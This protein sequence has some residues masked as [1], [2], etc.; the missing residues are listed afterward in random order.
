MSRLLANLTF[1]ALLIWAAPSVAQP[2]NP[3]TT[4]PC[5]GVTSV[6]VTGS[7]LNIA[8]GA[9]VTVRGCNFGNIPGAVYL[10]NA[11]T[12]AGST[13][14]VQQSPSQWQPT[15]V[16]IGSVVVGT[17]ANTGY[18]YVSNT[19]GFINASAPFAVILP[20]P[21]VAPVVTI[22]VPTSAPTFNNGTTA[23]VSLAGTATDTTGVTGCTWTNSL[24]G[25]GNATGT[26]SWSIATIPLMVGT[27]VI[28]VQCLDPALHAG[29][30][31]ISVT[32]TD[33]CNG[34]TNICLSSANAGAADGSSCANARVYTY[35]NN[36]ANWG[37]GGAEIDPGDTVFICGT[38]TTAAATVAFNFQG[39]GTVGNPITLKWSDGAIVQM[40]YFGDGYNCNGGGAINVGSH[41]NIVIDGG[42]NGILKATANG[43]ARANRV[44]PSTGIGM[45]TVSNI[46]IK[47]LDILDLFVSVKNG[48]LGC[49]DNAQLEAINVYGGGSNVSIHDNLFDHCGWCIQ[50]DW[51]DGDTG[52]DI[53]N[54]EF[55][56]WAHGLAFKTDIAGA[57][58]LA[59]CLKFHDNRLHDTSNWDYTPSCDG[60][61][62]GLHVFTVHDTGSVS[63][64]YAYNNYF[65]GDLGVCATGSF[66]IEGGGDQGNVTNGNYWNNVIILGAGTGELTN[67]WF[68]IFNGEGGT[69]R[70]VNNTII[71]NNPSN[72]SAGFGLQKIASLV[73]ENNITVDCGD[74]VLSQANVT[75]S[76]F[77]RNMY[78]SSCLNGAN[79]FH[80][81][82]SSFLGSFAAWKAACGCDA[83]SISTS[84]PG[85]DTATAALNAG[86]PAIDVGANLT[87]IATGLLSTLAND[88]TL[89]NTRTPTA[90]PQ[91]SGW[92]IGADER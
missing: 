53:Y 13:T 44:T 81:N 10:C 74:P 36:A 68:G 40:P 67:T 62:T 57:N 21:D 72:N 78:G 82:D 92:D 20:P 47:N 84:S 71:C 24:G 54:N 69:T 61:M 35:F 88:T 1:L 58:C 15:A 79:C 37:G 7:P 42:T 75:I 22:T 16:T 19:G 33:G 28:T 9:P 12:F 64:L 49:C 34:T 85:V 76:V 45:C 83:N 39:G 80:W 56:H 38:I 17:L 51:H 3:T 77:D 87:S 25:G 50:V 18:W 59:T 89:G 66:F 46:E 14:C 52:Y 91:G 30:D 6:V 29:T 60:H 43:S 86:S 26:T 32:R 65:Y 5:T 31:T 2:T 63:G 4:V 48:S 27:N 11:S 8:I 70:I 55:S 41:S 23:T 90:R 73:F